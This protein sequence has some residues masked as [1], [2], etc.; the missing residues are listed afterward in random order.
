MN[1][2][3]HASGREGTDQKRWEMHDRSVAAVSLVASSSC[4]FVTMGLP[5]K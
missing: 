3:E 4:Y 1:Q 2:Q 5:S